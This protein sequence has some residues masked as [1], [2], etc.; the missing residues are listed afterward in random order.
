MKNKDVI[1][2][3]YLYRQEQHEKNSAQLYPGSSFMLPYQF[4][5]PL[6][7]LMQLFISLYQTESLRRPGFNIMSLLILL[8]IQC[9]GEPQAVLLGEVAGIQI[10]GQ[11]LIVSELYRQ[12]GFLDFAT[13]M[14]HCGRV[15]Q[16]IWLAPHCL[17]LN[18]QPLCFFCK[19]KSI[20]IID[21]PFLLSFRYFN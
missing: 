17:C 18:L 16:L 15:P 3:F 12:W 13:K 6:L 5:V 4:S 20:T 19:K 10:A 8:V 14:R 9:T 2:R 21:R 11:E 1:P 7:V